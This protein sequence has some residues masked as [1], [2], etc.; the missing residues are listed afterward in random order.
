MTW[1][2][3]VYEFRHVCLTDAKSIK[4]S[5]GGVLMDLLENLD[6]DYGDPDGGD[7]PEASDAMK[8][9]AEA[10]VTVVLREFVVWACEET[11]EVVEVT[12]HEAR[13]MVGG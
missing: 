6:G 11:G 5:A 9:A 1:P 10:F 4:M 13:G 3:K 7:Y 2:V 8:A 12:R